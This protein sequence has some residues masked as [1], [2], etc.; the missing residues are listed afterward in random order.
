MI[1]RI[2]NLYHKL[3]SFAASAYYGLPAR[4]LTEIGVTGTD[5]K[6]TTVTMIHHVLNYAGIKTGL[7]STIEVK[8]GDKSYDSG[9]HVTTPDP[10]DVPKFLK[11]MV[12]QG[13]THVVI[14]TTSNGLDQNR[15]YGVKFDSA[16][17][18]NIRNDHL[19]YHKTWQR[20][21]EAKFKLIKQVKNE[22]FAVLN[23]DDADSAKWL[24]KKSE[25]LR[26]LV[27]A[28]WASKNDLINRRMTNRGIEFEYEGRKFSV[29]ILGEHNFEN[30]AQVIA[31][32]QKYTSIDQI[33]EALAS[34]KSPEG[35]MELIKSSPYTVVV[36]FAHTPAA[37]DRALRSL[38]QIKTDEKS[39]V[40]CVFGC[41][42]KRD[43]GRRMMGE[44]SARLA[45][46]TI[47][48]AEDP[49][50]EELGLINNEIMKY[51]EKSSGQLIQRFPNRKIYQ[52]FALQDLKNKSFEVLDK[53]AKPFFAFDEN[54]PR[55]RE[56]AIDFAL[57]LAEPG[58]IVFITGK[59]HEKSLS[60][61]E[62]EQEMPWSDQEVIQKILSQSI[63]EA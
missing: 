11:M 26:Q 52:S 51:A 16:V 46:V 22:G 9:L 61:G 34:F 31:V 37:L 38:E 62:P 12:K 54:T 63:S 59:G 4:H 5:G 19:D 56:D 60:F 42:G 55:S 20:Y 25:S 15:L 6:T 28:R 36:D 48:T 18:T 43:K 41:A 8:I 17:I 7:I 39:K 58:D 27:Y 10:W 30:I 40:I 23:S 21:A 47:L 57:K 49:R 24:S 2:K 50:D 14:E 13:I 3:Q 45:D 33:K 29:P 1:Q 44:I 35:R 32:C 53:G